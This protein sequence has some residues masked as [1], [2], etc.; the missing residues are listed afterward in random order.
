MKNKINKLAT[1]LLETLSNLP[2]KGRYFL[3]ITGCPAAGKSM[4]AR[5]LKDEINFRTGDDLAAVVPMDGFHLPN[6]ILKQRALSDIKGAPE[7]FD[8]DS[9]AELINRLHEFP[10]RSIMCPAY[11]RKIHD[12]VENSITILP[13]NQLIIVEGNYLLLNISPWNT[14]RTKM[15]EVWY[16]DTPLKTVKERLLHRHIAGGAGKDKAERKVTSVD[17]PNAVLVKKTLL[18]A[19]KVVNLNN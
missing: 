18:A 13:C 3:G 9:F 15:N 5:N 10:D 7:T 12:P 1:E 19:D 16:I 6:Y 14:I 2:D 11:N 8:A 17:L 4:L